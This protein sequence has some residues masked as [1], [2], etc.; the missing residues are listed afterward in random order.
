ME[1]CWIYLS[2]RSLR[3]ELLTIAPFSGQE[4]RSYIDK[5]ADVEELNPHR[6]QYLKTRDLILDRLS[7]VFR[8]PDEQPQ[9][10]FNSF[11]GYP[12]VLD[13]IGTLL[14]KEANYFKL[15]QQLTT[16]GS[17]ES[18]AQLLLQVTSRILERE[19]TEKVTENIVRPLVGDVEPSEQ[20]R[21]LREAY[22]PAEQ[23]LRVLAHCLEEPIHLPVC[24]DQR[25]REKYEEQL[26]A[27]VPEHP[28]LSGRSI[29]NAVFEA[30]VISTVLLE[31]ND[32]YIPLLSKYWESS[33]PNYHLAYILATLKPAAKIPVGSIGMLVDSAMEFNSRKASADIV[34]DGSL[35]DD[36]EGC[37]PAE[38]AVDIEITFD[39]A[40]RQ[41]YGFTSEV[42]PDDAIAIHNELASASVI[43]PC[44]VFLRSGSELVLTGPIDIQA[45]RIV[46]S[47]PS[48][49]CRVDPILNDTDIALE[50][51]NIESVVEHVAT[52]GADLSVI[53]KI[54]GKLLHPLAK[55]AVVAEISTTDSDLQRKFMR[56]RRILS[57]FRSHSKGTLAR[58]KGK[59]EH[60]RVL[61][62]ETGRKV[63][64][65]LVKD[66]ILS[67]VD[68]HY[69]LN[70]KEIDAKLGIGWTGLRR[71]HLT[72]K[73]RSWLLKI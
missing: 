62:N 11:I 7:R 65:Q 20:T 59:I 13:A 47:A 55:Y 1:D 33:K 61:K 70:D 45:R 51:N 2:G 23:C 60:A 73:M 40:E 31:W 49:T 8:D 26:A 12:P 41:E 10:G 64:N 63:L 17:N 36:Y 43:V 39:N 22:R 32:E 53:Q 3:C 68:T 42:K 4:A 71:G 16:Q 14:H 6:G 37:S 35:S 48:I 5:V 50:A 30:Y 24:E 57:E 58:Y 9:S 67:L 34:I 44:S 27:F 28:F 29:R 19:Q 46:L 66:G 21:M 52:N 54:G 69:F 18:E 15:G 25:L 72:P 38:I 56:V